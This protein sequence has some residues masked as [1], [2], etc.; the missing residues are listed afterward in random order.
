MDSRRCRRSAAESS[1]GR[2]ELMEEGA[3]TTWMGLSP[4]GSRVVL[5]SP[6]HLVIHWTPDALLGQEPQYLGL[7]VLEDLELLGEGSALLF[8]A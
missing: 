1:A 2:T 3:S 7:A 5:A 8:V 6:T 4:R